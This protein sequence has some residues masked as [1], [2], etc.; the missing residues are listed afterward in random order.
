MIGVG[1]GVGN[2][3][4]WIMVTNYSVLTGDNVYVAL[5]LASSS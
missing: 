3:T 1:V 5:Y 2:N 4:C